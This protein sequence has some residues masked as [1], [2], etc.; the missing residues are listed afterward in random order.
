MGHTQT[1]HC[2]VLLGP[3]EAAELPSAPLK[4]T[5]LSGL[6]GHSLPPGGGYTEEAD[7]SWPC[8]DPQ[9]RAGPPQTGLL[10]TGGRGRRGPRFPPLQL[11]LDGREAGQRRALTKEGCGVWGRWGVP[12]VL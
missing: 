11:S 10:V 5:R 8:W 9:D 12:G 6:K 1:G 7:L 3:L 2:H 4:E